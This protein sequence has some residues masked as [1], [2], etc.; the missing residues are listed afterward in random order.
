GISKETPAPQCVQN[1]I[2][3]WTTG[4]GCSFQFSTLEPYGCLGSGKPTG[5]SIR[6]G[7]ITNRM[8]MLSA[9]L[10]CHLGQCGVWPLFQ[11]SRLLR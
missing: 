1:L 3:E 11:A 2:I 6:L 10:F 8:K 7:T 4:F 5:L 9:I